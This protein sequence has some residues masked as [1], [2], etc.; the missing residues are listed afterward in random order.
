MFNRFRASGYKTS[1]FHDYDD[2]YYQRSI[3]HYNL[4]SEK[5]YNVVD[6]GIPYVSNGVEWPNDSLMMGQVVNLAKDS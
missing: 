5:F 4:G 1:S 6:L 3:Y 2:T